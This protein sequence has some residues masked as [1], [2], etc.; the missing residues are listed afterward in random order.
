[1]ANDTYSPRPIAPQIDFMP[2]EETLEGFL[3]KDQRVAKS[4]FHPQ[5]DGVQD[6]FEEKIEALRVGC[7]DSQ[8]NAE[9][10][11]IEDLVNKRVA[12]HLKDILIQVQNA[13]TAT[14]KRRKGE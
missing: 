8:L 1:M 10:Y 4:Y 13:V 11:K 12:V 5:W 7:T 2:E 9:E 14:E 6:L 3:E